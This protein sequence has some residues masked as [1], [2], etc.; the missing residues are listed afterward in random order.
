MFEVTQRGKQCLTLRGES[1][2]ER[3]RKWPIVSEEAPKGAMADIR[4]PTD[5]QRHG[6]AVGRR[7]CTM[8]A[9]EDEDDERFAKRLELT[10]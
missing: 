9:C 8:R 2:R 10:R 1:T 3:L 7:Q 5:R 4:E 6:A